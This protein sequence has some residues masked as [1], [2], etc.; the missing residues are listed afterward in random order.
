MIRSSTTESHPPHPTRSVCV[1]P[2]MYV[3]SILLLCVCVS[4]A[5]GVDSMSWGK[6]RMRVVFPSLNQHIFLVSPPRPHSSLRTQARAGIPMTS[7]SAHRPILLVRRKARARTRIRA[8]RLICLPALRLSSHSPP[9]L[10]RSRRQRVLGYVDYCN[11]CCTF[12]VSAVVASSASSL[13]GSCRSFFSHSSVPVPYY[14][15]MCLIM[16]SLSC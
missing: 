14:S 2:V 6:Q 16:L 3:V 13:N 4:V 1:F 9:C 10:V 8:P 7:Q 15:L 12:L 11:M 5:F